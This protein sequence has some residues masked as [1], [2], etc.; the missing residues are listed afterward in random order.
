MRNARLLIFC[1][2]LVASSA[3]ANDYFLREADATQFEMLLEKAGV[4]PVVSGKKSVV[5]AEKIFCRI[6]VPTRS[7]TCHL[8]SNKKELTLKGTDA[9]AMLDLMRKSGLKKESLVSGISVTSSKTTCSSE[10]K[11]NL[12][13][14][15]LLL[16]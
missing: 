13:Y 6:I 12:N 2:A 4:K 5:K 1:C 10:L 14:I 11:N 7:M 3:F 8:N 15:C 16:N 9:K